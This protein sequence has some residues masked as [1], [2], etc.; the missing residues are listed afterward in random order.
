[1]SAQTFHLYKVFAD[2][3]G[4]GTITS[5]RGH[6]LMGWGA[7]YVP[8]YGIYNLIAAGPIKSRPSDDGETSA[9]FEK[10]NGF[11]LLL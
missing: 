9:E 4:R 5:H 6:G 2:H 11:E 7:I 1:M 3:E 8:G 10:W